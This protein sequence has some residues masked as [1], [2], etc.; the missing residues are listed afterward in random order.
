MK[1]SILI[2]HRNFTLLWLHE[3]K[4]KVKY[5]YHSHLYSSI[6]H[7]VHLRNLQKLRSDN[8][9]TV[10]NKVMMYLVLEK[11]KKILY[12]YVRY[13]FIYCK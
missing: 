5:L 10:K 1:I 3:P 4:R 2:T 6:N 12:V 11:H 8:M 7:F 13:G 9:E